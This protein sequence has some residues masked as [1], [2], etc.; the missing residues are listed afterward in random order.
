[1]AFQTFV[2][3]QT[4]T[5]TIQNYRFGAALTQLFPL[6]AIKT[7][8]SLTKVLQCYS[9]SFYIWYAI[10]FLIIL[11]LLKS[12]ALAIILLLSLTLITSS[13]FYWA[14]TELPQGISFLVISLSAILFYA[15]KKAVTIIQG[16]FLLA[17]LITL[18]FFHPLLSI[19][20]IL[21]I[22]YFKLKENISN[23]QFLILVFTTIFLVTLKSLFFK[24]GTY[25]S[26]KMGGLNNF[27]SLFPNYFSINSNRFFLYQL[28]G[29]YF[30]A[31]TLFLVTIVF[32]LQRKKYA[33]LLWMFASVI[34]YIM[35]INVSFPNLGE[36]T[37]LQ[38]MHLPVVV[39]LSLPFAF[40]IVPVLKIKHWLPVLSLVFLVRLSVI[41]NSH[42]K[43]TT[44]LN[45]L[46]EIIAAT[47]SYEGRKFWISDENIPSEYFDTWALS[48]ET[49]ILSSL[50][51][52]DSSRTIASESDIIPN[53][54][55]IKTG[56]PFINPYW[57]NSEALS[58]NYFR[59]PNSE[60]REIKLKD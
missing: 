33:L 47:H 41:Y 57:D 23:Q 18:V 10:Y 24:T 55:L 56:Y 2:M 12:E 1:M 49:L 37:Y 54:S 7:H 25:E 28:I 42:T 30:F 34:T 35:L 26:N 15:Q 52:P 60:Y 27:I 39:L 16:I 17:M 32:Y 5:T 22:V 36:G 58:T 3:I 50:E 13:S 14:Q 40:E 48:Y 31:A 43:F 21:S 59:L 19:I 46:K 29:N 45:A 8:L 44:R 4:K 11:Y 51:S 6:I 38:N 20:F 53:K 9:V